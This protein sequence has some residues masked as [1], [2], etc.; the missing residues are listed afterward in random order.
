MKRVLI[1]IS[2]IVTLGILI[3]SNS[4]HGGFCSDDYMII[5]ENLAI[6]NIRNIA[7]LWQVFNTR[8]IAG[9]SFALNYQFGGFN[10]FGYHAVNIAVHILNAIL[11]YGLVHVIFKTPAMKNTFV[12]AH[13]HLIGFTA[14]LIFLCHPIQTETVAFI[15]QRMSALAT[16]FYLAAVIFYIEGRLNGRFWYL[17]GFFLMMSVGILTKELVV[18]LPLIL[19]ICEVFLFEA[20]GRSLGSRLKILLPFFLLVAVFFFVFAQNRMDSIWKLKA[21]AGQPF[22]WEYFLTEINVLRTY[23]RLAF[24]PVHLQHD[25]DY[26]IVARVFEWPTV[27]SILLLIAIAGFS[28]W[29][30]RRQRLLSFS[31]AWFF[32]TVLVEVAHPCFVKGGVIYEHWLYLP[33]AGFSIFLSFALFLI[34]G[35]RLRF[36]IVLLFIVGILSMLTYERNKAWQSEL[37]LWQDNVLKAPRNPRAYLGLGVAY[38]HLGD[39]AREIVNYEKAISFDPEYPKAYNNLAV[40]YLKLGRWDKVAQ[41]ARN[42]IFF[43]PNYPEAYATLAAHNIV[44]KQYAEA[45]KNLQI[46]VELYYQVGDFQKAQVTQR[47]L[48]TISSYAG[49][50]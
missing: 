41:Y 22:S 36:K 6:E 23:V 29:Q 4:L 35:N 21:Q 25:Y 48:D 5:V 14:A 45:K 13:A 16:F 39:H 42:A 28:V 27:F 26:P 40:A 34:L 43:S 10:V 24:F 15:S 2:A 1:S 49:T 50:P 32:M 8:F 38:G 12:R 30:F 18:T 37:T 46:S 19:I 44:F 20:D 47:I 33:M 3:Y 9:L 17:A 11:L 7:F 31:I